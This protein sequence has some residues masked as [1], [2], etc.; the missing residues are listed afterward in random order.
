MFINFYVE[1]YNSILQ[2]FT[3]LI[4]FLN[5]WLLGLDLQV[6]LMVLTKTSLELPIFF[7]IR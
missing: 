7:V 4:F 5:F 3:K 2:R 1:I 6:G